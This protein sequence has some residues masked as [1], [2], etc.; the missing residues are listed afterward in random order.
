[1]APCLLKYSSHA[2]GRMF[3]K[4][5]KKIRYAV[6][7]LG[8]ISYSGILP[9]FS[10]ASQNSE[11]VAIVSR[12]SEKLRFYSE[13]YHIPHTFLM[14]DILHLLNS[15][16]IDAIYIATPY[17]IAQEIAELASEKEIHILS[18]KPISLKNNSQKVMI[19]YRHLLESA[20]SEIQK[21]VH[22][23]KIGEP[24]IFNSTLSYHSED[25]D[26]RL[27]YNLG[28][29]CINIA[30]RIFKS[31]PIEVF[32]NSHSKDTISLILKFPKGQLANLN[33]SSESIQTSDYEIIGTTGRIRLEEA[34]EYAKSMTMKFYEKNKITIKR[35][36]RRDL[37]SRILLSFSSTIQN[38][39][40]SIETGTDD[41]RI[42]KA[43]ELSLDL[44]T[45][46]SLRDFT[47]R[48]KKDFDVSSLPSNEPT[49][50]NQ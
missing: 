42:I 17:P 22:D 45:P 50:M 5:Q 24:R 47:R 15:S 30:R 43:I 8:E 34:Y 40:T 32:A 16:L 27:L 29:S 25:R 19:A 4:K 14:K 23:G 11:L 26:E 1:M 10:R 2:E 35:Y 48:K 20:N 46:I 36:P 41:I 7:G 6:I 18:D 28:G 33:I 21:F 38:N 44:G 9:N 39:K 49:W 37:F 31:D 3:K 13:K 12:S